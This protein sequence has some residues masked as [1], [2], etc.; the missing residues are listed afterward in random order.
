M[1]RNDMRYEMNHQCRIPPPA[2]KRFFSVEFTVGDSAPSYLFKLRSTESKPMFVLIKENSEILDQLEEGRTLT[3][4]FHSHDT[5]SPIEYLE[6][7]ITEISPD[8]YGRFKGHYLVGLSI[9][10]SQTMRQ[11][12]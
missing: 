6:A 12:H 10:Q 7:R 3:L 9:V 8:N 2:T 11:I 1:I 5:A 4:K